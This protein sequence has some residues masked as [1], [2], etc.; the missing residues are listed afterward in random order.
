M[1][2]CR[3]SLDL[4]REE[5]KGMGNRRWEGR[6]IGGLAKTE[7]SSYSL[8]ELPFETMNAAAFEAVMF[9]LGRPLVAGNC[10]IR[11]ELGAHPAR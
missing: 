11:V 6:R 5:K 4:Q 10:S 7:V 3:G 2:S 9:T 8:F 1:H